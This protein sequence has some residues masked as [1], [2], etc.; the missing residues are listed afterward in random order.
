MTNVIRKTITGTENVVFDV[1][2]NNT[3]AFL[4]DLPKNVIVTNVI[5]TGKA[6]NKTFVTNLVTPYDLANS[7]YVSFPPDTYCEGKTVVAVLH[8]EFDGNRIVNA[9][10]AYEIEK[11]TVAYIKTAIVEE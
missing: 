3:V 2:G 9:A 1:F 10:K 5:V 7:V 11:F 6:N 8:S 4:A